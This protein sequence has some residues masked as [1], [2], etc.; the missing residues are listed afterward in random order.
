MY[1]CIYIY[2][3]ISHNMYVCMSWPTTDPWCSRCSRGP[4]TRSQRRGSPHR[5]D[6]S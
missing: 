4:A 3:C 5:E 6:A 1:I 2:I